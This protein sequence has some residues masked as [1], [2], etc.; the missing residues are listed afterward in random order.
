MVK[1]SK[2]YRRRTRNV[3]QKRARERGLSPITHQFQ[4]FEIGEMANIAIDPSVHKGMPHVKF[5][6]NTGTVV[7]QSGKAYRVDFM[8][9]GKKKQVIARPEHLRKVNKQGAKRVNKQGTEQ[10]TKQIAKQ[11]AKQIAKQAT[12]QATK[13]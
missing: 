1:S 11:A 7:S 5:Q 3:L 2:G 10:A 9:G 6:G 12:K 4:K 8:D 13:P